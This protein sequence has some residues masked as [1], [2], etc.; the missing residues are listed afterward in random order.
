MMWIGLIGGT[1]LGVL[2][3]WPW[4]YASARMLEQM[5]QAPDWTLYAPKGREG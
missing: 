2:I 1:M 3:G 5:R 4:G